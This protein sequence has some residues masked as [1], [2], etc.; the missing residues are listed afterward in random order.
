MP[1]YNITLDKDYM[2]GLMKNDSAMKK[3]FEDTLN[4][5][6]E[7][8]HNEHVSAAP[9]ERTE[10]R[11]A[12]QNGYWKRSLITR[13]DTLN[14]R[15]PGTRDGTFST[16]LFDRYQRSEQAF[17][18]TLIEM[19]IN[20]VS[21]RKVTRVVE[22]LCGAEISRSMVS[23]LCRRLDPVVKGWNQRPL[24]TYPFLIVDALVIKVRKEGRVRQ[25]S[26]LLAIGINSDGYREI[27]GFH[28]GDSES[29]SSWEEFFR[30][31]KDRGL[32][33]VDLVV[34]DDHRGLVRAV[35][36]HFQ[37]A[38]WQRCQAHFIR[39]IVNACPKARKEEMK[40]RL[41]MIF[42]APDMAT[43]RHL[44][45]EMLEIYG[46]KAS[47]AMECL[48]EGFEDAM[49]VMALPVRYR[50]RLRTTNGIE[51]LN[52]EIRR[53][54]RVIR[55]FPNDASAVRLLGALLMETD[56]NWSTGHRYFDMA[57]YW[58]GRWREEQENDSNLTKIE[59][60]A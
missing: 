15:V 35:Y 16:D 8:Q 48:E 18:L 7:E 51:R 58:G 52:E 42:D 50:K 10:N 24:G 25:E 47:R 23:N 49:A 30:I 57:E 5:I 55:I 11:K 34:S 33:G 59:K 60:V 39:N 1:H 28:V 45:A 6:M 22:E 37:G 17:V 41:R 14:L 13:I 9:F 56:E 27:L 19:V 32:N 38:S 43:A 20:G 31:L 54:E 44:L 4:K 2:Q 36:K 46:E 26:V 3:L 21:T 53:R 40:L 29:A 12:Q